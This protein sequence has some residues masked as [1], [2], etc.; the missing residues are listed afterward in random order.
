MRTDFP[1]GYDFGVGSVHPVVHAFV[2]ALGGGLAYLSFFKKKKS[3]SLSSPNDPILKDEQ[4]Q[5]NPATIKDLSRPC[6]E[7]LTTFTYTLTTPA[8]FRP[9]KTALQHTMDLQSNPVHDLILLDKTYRQRLAYRRNLLINHPSETYGHISASTWAVSEF[10]TYIFSY[11][12]PTRFP[13]HFSKSPSGTLV[14]NHTTTNTYPIIA[15]SASNALRALGENLDEDYTI[16]IPDLEKLGGWKVGAFVVCYS[17]GVQISEKLDCE[18]GDAVPGFERALG[19]EGLVRFLEKLAP[20]VDNGVRRLNWT[21]AKSSELYTPNSMHA[22]DSEDEQGENANLDL[23]DCCLK[24]Q[25]Q[26]LWKLPTSGA[27]VSSI[28]T[29]MYPLSEIKAEEGG[30][31]EMLANAIESLG[32]DMGHYNCHGVWGKQVLEY[33]RG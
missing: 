16:L 25:R 13:R 7:P 28:K 14:Q 17:S 24:V 29:Y 5:E 22:Y 12:L 32:K 6:L 33:L 21:I 11:H 10:Y 15:Q 23:Q 2:I 9:Y 26:T 4:S 31:S 18:V 30:E 19:G 8:K 1:V 20:G 27:I 3:A